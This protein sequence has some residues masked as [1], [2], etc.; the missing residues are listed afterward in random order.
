MSTNPTL[1]IPDTERKLREAAFFLRFIEA[2]EG[3]PFRS[4][5]EPFGLVI[6][7]RV[8]EVTRD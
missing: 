7:Y 6:D 4:E 5:P 2:T 3:N 8:N 1:P